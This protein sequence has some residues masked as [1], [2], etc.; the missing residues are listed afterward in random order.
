MAP[1]HLFTYSVWFPFDAMG[2]VPNIR[3]TGSLGGRP[4][5]KKN[6]EYPV[7]SLTVQ[8]YACTTLFTESFHLLFL[9]SGK[10]RNMDNNVLLNRSAFPFV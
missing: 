2:D 5:S 6:G 1:F 10:V 8:L 3:S 9:S 4:N 7:A